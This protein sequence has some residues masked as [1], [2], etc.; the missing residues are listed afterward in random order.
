MPELNSELGY[1]IVLTVIA[2]ACVV[3]YFRFKRAG[4]L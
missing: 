3:L 4:W 2:I 1:P